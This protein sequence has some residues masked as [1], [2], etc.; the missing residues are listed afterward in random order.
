MKKKHARTLK[1]FTLTEMLMV[2]IVSGILFIALFDGV[3]LVRRYTN[4]LTVKLTS[5]ADLLDS[6][7]RLEHLFRTCDSV[8]RKEDAYVFYR[9]GEAQTVVETRDSLLCTIRVGRQ[10]T[11]LQQVTSVRT[12][13]VR[14]APALVDSLAVSFIYRGRQLHFFFG[15]SRRPERAF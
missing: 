11:L 3:D 1:A 9:E 10:D 7:H 6:F 13:A 4:R 14:G 2:M 8:Q 15:L 12:V 5:G